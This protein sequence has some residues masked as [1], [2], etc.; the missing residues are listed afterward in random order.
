MT[1]FAIKLAYCVHWIMLLDIENFI[2]S[3]LY[4]F[5]TTLEDP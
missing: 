4:L 3:V 1:V 5:A 2:H